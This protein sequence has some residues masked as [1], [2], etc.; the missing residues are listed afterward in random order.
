MLDLPRSGESTSPTTVVYRSINVT[1]TLPAYFLHV[2][3]QSLIS[4]YIPP[5]VFS[6]LAAS[7][8]S[9][10]AVASVTGDAT[11]LVYA[12]LEDT[13]RPPWFT[14][15]VPSTY[16]AQMSTLEAS[17]DELKGVARVDSTQ[18]P[19]STGMYPPPTSFSS[20]ASLLGSSQS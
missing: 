4:T 9:A 14:S 3:A 6:E 20:Q 13:S 17:L 19:A 12:A 16:A 1:S 7:V 18:E 11:S 15:A 2:S 5:A 8:A 10:A